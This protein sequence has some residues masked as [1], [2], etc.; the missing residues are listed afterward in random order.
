MKYIGEIVYE[1][2]GASAD[3]PW[4]DYT[5]RQFGDISEKATRHL[6]LNSVIESDKAIDS[7]KYFKN[8]GSLVTSAASDLLGLSA[9][10]SVKSVGQILSAANL[11]LAV[12]NS[13]E[14]NDAKR[15]A[16]EI[17]EGLPFF[18]GTLLSY[19]EILY[20]AFNEECNGYQNEGQRIEG[21]HE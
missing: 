5:I 20:D 13:T 12:C 4:F 11:S 10:K 15:A 17:A 1:D 14:H 7:Y 6:S 19:G 3:A 9:I 2:V 21:Y 8:V 16:F 18:A